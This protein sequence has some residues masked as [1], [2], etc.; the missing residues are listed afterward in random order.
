VT[1]ELAANS[2]G[3]RVTLTHSGWTEEAKTYKSIASGWKEILGLLKH[4]L[5]T[6]NIPLKTR[7]IYR[8]MGMFMF[9][10]PKSTT[11]EEVGR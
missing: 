1:W 5:E 2:G 3:C 11:V 6:G 7:M 4:G 8:L 9:T 10:M